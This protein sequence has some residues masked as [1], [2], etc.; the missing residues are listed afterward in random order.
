MSK[1][2]QFYNKHISETKLLKDNPFFSILI[3]FPASI[4]TSILIIPMTIISYPFLYLFRK[5]EIKIMKAALYI[6]H[7][8]GLSTWLIMEEI[9]LSKL[10]SVNLSFG[11]SDVI[12]HSLIAFILFYN[13][14]KEMIHETLNETYGDDFDI[15]DYSEN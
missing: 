15:S 13:S 2:K 5:Q 12:I 6:Q 8:I 3:F 11:F 1:I 4:T 7:S 9:L 10:F 14:I